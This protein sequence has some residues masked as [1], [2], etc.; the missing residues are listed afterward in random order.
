MPSTTTTSDDFDD[1][2]VTT[3]RC[4]ERLLDVGPIQGATISESNSATFKRSLANTQYGVI[5]GRRMNI[6]ARFLCC[7]IAGIAV[8]AP[9]FANAQ[10]ATNT[11]LTSDT[12]L[13]E[14]IV[15]AQRRA[16]RLEDVPISVTAVSGQ[17]LAASGI[18]TSIDL[19]MVT[20]GLKMDTAG[21]YVQPAIRGITS[22]IQ[23]PNAESNVATYVDG[24]YF[25]NE[26]G[27]IYALPD[28][29]DVEVLKGPQGTLFGRNAT[30]GAILIN[31]IA[32]SLT[33]TTGMV[34]GS[35]GSFNMETEEGFLSVPLVPDK[36]AMSVT[37]YHYSTTG[38]ERNLLADGQHVGTGEKDDLFRAKIRFEP[39]DGADFTLTD[40]YSYTN[41]RDGFDFTV[42]NGNSAFA[43]T[44]GIIIASQPNTFAQAH[45]PDNHVRQEAASLRGEIQLGPGTLVTTTAYQDTVAHLFVDLSDV[46]VDLGSVAY[47]STY[48]DISQ[49][50]LYTTQQLGRFRGVGGL[51]YFQSQGGVLPLE[52]N[53][54]V[55]PT[56]ENDA[57]VIWQKDADHSYAVFA[58]GTFDI[59]DQLSITGGLRY[60][61]E[62]VNG[63]ASIEY[64]TNAPLLPGPLG[65]VTYNNTTPR[66]SVVYKL[67]PDT[68][69]YFT[70]SQGFKSGVFNSTSFQTTPVKPETVD[71]YEVGFKSRSLKTL[72]FDVAAYYYVYKDLQ[73][74]ALLTIDNAITQI[75]T[76]AATAKIYG[77][78]F[79]SVW[80]ATNALKFSA[81]LEY[82]HARY[83]NFPDASLD[84]PIPGCVCGNEN[85]IGNVSGNTMIRSPTISGNLSG[86]YSWTLPIGA[87][88]LSA[89]V[90]ATSKIYY[91]VG[92]RLEQ[93][94]YAKV[95]A[96]L[97]WRVNGFDVSVWGRN[98]T[99]RN[100]IASILEETL[101]DA[102][103]Y[104]PP[105]QVGGEVIYRF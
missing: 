74:P 101:L 42:L 6:Y 76:N 92:D 60:N 24:V 53:T 11:D 49:E 98:L 73:V 102:A 50:F 59:T 61:R 80:Q 104:E 45:I 56:I 34:G 8:G 14:V 13:Q 41:D 105:R 64:L 55:G 70:Y 91:D 33:E 3:Q 7:T 52:I 66:A 29:Q 103:T 54:F 83:S 27:A 71:A 95:N 10:Q 89:I 36:L 22:T 16:E 97:T 35:Y 78:E 69:V 15:T 21:A 31:T 93:P 40:M 72:S 20:P 67:D 4:S 1:V 30:G 82:L 86:S 84:V 44:P 58:D 47:A 48:T 85:V 99:N 68:N 87:L 65:T 62:R 75:L 26:Q 32:P 63:N 9:P 25:P 39:W 37:A 94:G 51:Y 18:T 96:K 19:T 5:T 17:Q 46:P 28:V 23:Q 88:D 77:A 2:V 12:T 90:F 43:G 38:W 79:D 57:E 81:G 100:I